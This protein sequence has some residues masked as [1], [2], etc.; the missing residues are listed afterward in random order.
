MA[1]D[2]RTRAPG[3]YVTDRQFWLG[4]IAVLTVLGVTPFAATEWVFSRFV[5]EHVSRAVEKHNGAGDAHHVI[6]E[7]LAERA[8]TTDKEI[9]M[10]L[11]DMAARLARIEGA[12]DGANVNG[13]RK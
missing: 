4:L 3:Y 5:D 13:K 1:E 11:D 6:V 9:I 2:H 7:R 8:F 10:R 12:I